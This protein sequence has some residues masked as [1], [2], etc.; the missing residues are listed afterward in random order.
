MF[1]ILINNNFLFNK[2]KCSVMMFKEIRMRFFLN[3]WN[4][5]MFI[6]YYQ[7]GE[8]IRKKIN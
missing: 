2:I 4:K 1:I 8:K 3:L 5:E 7:I 6:I